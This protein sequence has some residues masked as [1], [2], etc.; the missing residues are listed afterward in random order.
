M[1][2]FN[3]DTRTEY[4]LITCDHPLM[5]DMGMG[6]FTLPQFVQWWNFKDGTDKYVNRIPFADEKIYGLSTIIGFSRD[7]GDN[8][9][10]KPWRFEDY[11]IG[12]YQRYTINPELQS[13]DTPVWNYYNNNPDC[14]PE[15]LDDFDFDALQMNDV[16]AKTFNRITRLFEDYITE[17]IYAADLIALNDY[18]NIVGYD[19]E[20]DF[21]RAARQ[22]F[23]D[24]KRSKNSGCVTWKNKV[25]V[26]LR[27]TQDSEPCV[28]VEEFKFKLFL[29]S[30]KRPVDRT[31]STAVESVKI[32][33]PAIGPDG[34][35]AKGK[36]D[37]ESTAVVDD[38]PSNKLGG[39]LKTS[40]RSY[41][42]KFSA[43]SEEIFGIVSSETIPAA[44]WMDDPEDWAK[45][46]D[47]E[48][49]FR[50][51]DGQYLIPGTGEIF[52]LDL[53]NG[54]PFQWAPNYANP[55]GCR[56]ENKDKVK[57][58]VFNMSPRSYNKSDAVTATDRYSL[59]FIDPLA[60]SD[61]TVNFK[62]KGVRSW[63]FSYFLTNEPHYLRFADGF[64]ESN[65]GGR[66]DSFTHENTNAK[67]RDAEFS[68]S[69]KHFKTALGQAEYTAYFNSLSNKEKDA[70]T[71]WQGYAQLTSWDFM[72]PPFGGLRE[73]KAGTPSQAGGTAL[74]QD[75]PLGNALVLTASRVGH[76]GNVSDF[77][78]IYN[79][80][81]T[82]AR[83][84]ITAPFFGCAFPDGY[85]A[86][87]KYSL[88]NGV[89]KHSD[90]TLSGSGW[91]PA[92]YSKG[93]GYTELTQNESFFNQ[94][95]ISYISQNPMS[96]IFDPHSRHN[97]VSS[98]IS[99][100][101]FL[102][103]DQKDPEDDN[104]VEH[105]NLFS[106]G[107]AMN[108]LP[109]DIALNASWKGEYGGP[110]PNLNNIQ[111]YITNPAKRKS[112]DAD[113]IQWD[114]AAD[115][116]ANFHDFFLDSG[117]FQW[118]YN[119]IDS[120][121]KELVDDP[122][123][124]LLD[125]RPQDP[126][127]V[128]FRPARDGLFAQFDPPQRFITPSKFVNGDFCMSYPNAFLID[129]GFNNFR[130]FTLASA[131]GTYGLSEYGGNEP[132]W[133]Y[134]TKNRLIFHDAG[135][136]EDDIINGPSNQ[137]GLFIYRESP[138][139]NPDPDLDGKIMPFN[140]SA[141]RNNN[142]KEWVGLKTNYQCP[143]EQYCFTPAVGHAQLG[144][145]P[146]QESRGMFGVIGAIM[147]TS[148]PDE[149]IEFVTESYIGQPMY[150]NVPFFA[151][152]G[153]RSTDYYD[154]N[155]TALYVKVYES[156]PREQLIYDPRFYAVHHFNAGNKLQVSENKRPWQDGYTF[157]EEVIH[158]VDGLSSRVFSS[159]TQ[160]ISTL[161]FMFQS[162]EEVITSGVPIV[163]DKSITNV[164][165]RQ[166]SFY[167][168]VSFPET[169]VGG[170][171]NVRSIK[172]F[173]V[174]HYV[175]KEGARHSL[176]S[177]VNFWM[178]NNETVQSLDNPYNVPSEQDEFNEWETFRLARQKYTP[179][180][181][182]EHWAIDN[183]R[184]ARM[185]PWPY[186]KTVIAPQ[187]P[188]PIDLS[189]VRP[190]QTLYDIVQA[191]G[192]ASMIIKS[193]GKDYVVGER[194]ELQGGNGTGASVEIKQVNES[195]SPIAF[196]W[197]SDTFTFY[198]E[199]FLNRLHGEG[200]LPEDFL[201]GETSGINVN[202]S[203]SI[204]LIPESGTNRSFV[205][206]L[207]VGATYKD[208]VIDYKPRIA[209]STKGPYKLSAP[210]NS[211]LEAGAVTWRDT[212]DIEIIP[213]GQ[214]VIL[215][216]GTSTI[217]F[218]ALENTDAVRATTTAQ[219]VISME[220]SGNPNVVDGDFDC[221]FYAVNDASHT[222]IE[223]DGQPVTVENYMTMKVN[224]Y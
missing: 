140:Y 25:S 146:G 53:Q 66:T 172:P 19:L 42:G 100:F 218:P 220:G 114:N 92:S 105:V 119:T 86:E 7:Y 214:G 48:Q 185:L 2:I 26:N 139:G 168:N 156:W 41:D 121:K 217:G 52:P 23:K 73:L 115:V 202:T 87:E 194:F 10:I 90:E 204:K 157:G 40:Y 57:L 6:S 224:A 72:A 13:F 77:N 30:K 159:G 219:V 106:T 205:G 22:F 70:G 213:M 209:T 132:L 3:K 124:S 123:N 180:A 199:S 18:Y 154:A 78:E 117:S 75:T 101:Y 5:M 192:G 56:G 171:P 16:K 131:F 71:S 81:G 15:D 145:S 160:E 14:P 151:S 120:N 223:S 89:P 126:S 84:T 155:S 212:L 215:G 94:S 158:N 110:I 201:A 11:N 93:L 174:P 162:K 189:A 129:C 99:P 21:D 128:D 221:F 24:I 193:P 54:N 50:N 27:L 67:H 138:D 9:I 32:A 98:N 137:K 69:R 190:E 207:L 97:N 150:G 45:N 60:S 28:R 104:Y 127:R 46:L 83:G 65:G 152:A 64:Q 8:F 147:T 17:D 200:Y 175:F 33:A 96:G 111:K 143:L 170:E 216:D 37:G 198:D 148:A 195:G 61:I 179:I 116:Q 38:S 113:G 142:E 55:S 91:R 12:I 176:S 68:L 4:H 112:S 34:I 183:D 163:I 187:T 197:A 133:G 31:K 44:K 29:Y 82:V 173:E 76:D 141:Y 177:E 109:A 136:F 107:P 1:P 95:Y 134:K 108:H 39:D 118:L 222:W 135:G 206:Y 182:P 203:A 164:D 169:P 186:Y 188:Y 196:D 43:G 79:S 74:N 47:I 35:N 88:Y 20:K 149:G 166:P 161:N 191:Q 178:P 167:D 208:R 122:D 125:L 165:M 62:P 49:N 80:Y 85:L 36:E 184:R 181:K 59:W 63:Q 211:L 103:K 210:D 144:S 153:G 58:K 102:T 130:D 51:A